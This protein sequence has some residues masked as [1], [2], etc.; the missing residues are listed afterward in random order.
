MSPFNKKFSN[1]DDVRQFALVLVLSTLGF[2][3]DILKPG[4]KTSSGEVLIKGTRADCG[5]RLLAT[6]DQASFVIWHGGE[7]LAATS[8]VRRECNAFAETR[9]TKSKAYWLYRCE[10]TPRNLKALQKAVGA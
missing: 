10:V 6:G 2:A 8:A 7:P 1:Y 5:I 3:K 9:P 4:A